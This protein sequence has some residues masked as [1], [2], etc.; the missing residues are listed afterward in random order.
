MT[1]ARGTGS[2]RGVF[3]PHAHDPSVLRRCPVCQ[4][5]VDQDHAEALAMRG[6]TPAAPPHP[7][8]PSRAARDER[9]E[10]AAV[11]FALV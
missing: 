8:T 11:G 5:A 1:G 9:E 10:V 3:A 4:W 6:G 2:R 7:P